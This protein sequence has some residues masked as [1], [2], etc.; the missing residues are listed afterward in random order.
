MKSKST[1]IKN[2]LSASL[3]IIIIIIAI[4]W[5]IK[6]YQF[7]KYGIQVKGTVVRLNAGGSHPQIK[8]TTQDGKEIEFPQGGL[9]FGYKVGDDVDVLY[10]L[11]NPQDAAVNSFGV[12]W[13]FPLLFF[14]IGFIF[15]LVTILG[16]FQ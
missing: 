10:N 2:M 11:Q 8:F 13:G 1:Q 4:G 5:G 15:I 3:G 14:A 16:I 6:T 12:F 9:I 7:V